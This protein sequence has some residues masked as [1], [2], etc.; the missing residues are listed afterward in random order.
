METRDRILQLEL[1]TNR[2]EV[3]A[4]EEAMGKEKQQV[5]PCAT[6]WAL[7]W[8]EF[9]LQTGIPFSRTS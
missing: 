8:R 2:E 5:S 1:R 6:N 9:H 7:S 4:L 3:V